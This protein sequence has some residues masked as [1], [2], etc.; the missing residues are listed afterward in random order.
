[1]FYISRGEYIKC[2]SFWVSNLRYFYGLQNIEMYS[3]WCILWEFSKN[4]CGSVLS[5]KDISLE[6]LH[7]IAC[8]NHSS[9]CIRSK[10]EVRIT[11]V[12]GV[13]EKP[14]DFHFSSLIFSYC[15][16]RC[17]P[18]QQ[19]D[20]NITNIGPNYCKRFFL[21]SQLNS[22]GTKSF[23]WIPNN[24]TIVQKFIHL[25]Y[26]YRRYRDS[27]ENILNSS[28]Y[29]LDIQWRQLNHPLKPIKNSSQWIYS[30]CLWC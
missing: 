10:R 5:E 18:I 26:A 11:Y 3:V 29:A 22:K 14:E 6:F 24:R 13:M 17:Q 27:I 7:F 9:K 28:L 19:L 4:T 2:N 16:F 25:W 23:R 1:M 21:D 15:Y 12:S 8:S 20:D 30:H